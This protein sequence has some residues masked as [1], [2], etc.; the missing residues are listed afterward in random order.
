MS[1]KVVVGMRDIP[2]FSVMFFQFVLYALHYTYILAVW[3]LICNELVGIHNMFIYI[4]NGTIIV[5]I[6]LL[7]KISSLLSAYINFIC[8]YICSRLS[9]VDDD[10]NVVVTEKLLSTSTDLSLSFIFFATTFEF[11]ISFW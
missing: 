9:G 10:D 4:Q 7:K 2:I 6:G 3:L 1:I 11:T 8:H 5:K